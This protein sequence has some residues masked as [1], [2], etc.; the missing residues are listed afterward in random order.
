MTNIIILWVILF[1]FYVYFSSCTDACEMFIQ[2][3][4]MYLGVSSEVKLIKNLA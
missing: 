2:G 4:Y 1:Y 3:M